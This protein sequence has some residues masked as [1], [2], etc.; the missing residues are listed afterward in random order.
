MPSSELNTRHPFVQRYPVV[1][2]FAMTYAISWG[3]ALLVVAPKLMRGQPIPKLD[4]IL[5]FPVMLLGPSISGVFLTRI[6][7][8]K[9]G[10]S[11]LFSQMR[12]TRLFLKWYTALLIPPALIL[13]VLVGL[14]TFVSPVFAPNFFVMGLLFGV[15]AGFFEEIGWT[16]F[17]LPKMCR[18]FNPLTAS[19]L[20]GVLWGVWHLPVIDYLGTATPHGA[21]WFRYFLAFTAAMTAMRVVIGW[22]YSN[23]KSVLLAQLMHVSSTG[24]LVVFSAPRVTAPQEAGWYMAYAAALWIVVVMVA[25]QFRRLKLQQ[26]SIQV[27]I[28]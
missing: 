25:A 10:L 12:R 24:S 9:T 21:Y 2:Y 13:T 18:S 27:K 8:G 6:V 26:T 19:I 5:M 11:D 28:P 7:D 22:I 1:A 14:K 20:L 15:P 23:T 3:G 16:G 17:A 4:G